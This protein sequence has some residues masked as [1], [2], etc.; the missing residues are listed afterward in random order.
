MFQLLT[1]TALVMSVFTPAFATITDSPIEKCL[2]LHVKN[3]ISDQQAL[4]ALQSLQAGG[5]PDLLSRKVAN[6]LRSLIPAGI[7]KKLGDFG[8]QQEIF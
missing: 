6:Q 1:L 3:S 2:E 5:S 8:V 4:I 7:S